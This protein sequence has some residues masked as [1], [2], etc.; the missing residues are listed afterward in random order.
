MSHNAT[1]GLLATTKKWDHF[2]ENE[3][4]RILVPA[5]WVK[6]E[7]EGSGLLHGR[8]A[9]GSSMGPGYGKTLKV[10]ESTKGQRM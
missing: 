5:P 6:E 10:H 2:P 8:L 9:G 3:E 4:G 1:Y 7:G